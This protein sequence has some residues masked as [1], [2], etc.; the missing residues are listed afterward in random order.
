MPSTQQYRH[1]IAVALIATATAAC[2]ATPPVPEAPPAA[3]R[4]FYI[5][6]DGAQT[7]LPCGSG[8][9]L[10]V[11][12]NEAVLEPVRTRSM[13]RSKATGQPLQGVYAEIIGHLEPSRTPG[14]ANV[15]N[16][17]GATHLS[18]DLPPTCTTAPIVRP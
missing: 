16:A 13:A 1:L 5:Y 9:R 2:A 3:V 15:L 4:G 18:Y 7:L 11:I 17:V 10:Q 14:Y 6:Q 8:D 12:G